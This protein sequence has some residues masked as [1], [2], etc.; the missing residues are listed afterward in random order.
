MQHSTWLELS[1]WN[2]AKILSCSSLPPEPVLAPHCCQENAHIA[3]FV[4]PVPSPSTSLLSLTYHTPAAGTTLKLPLLFWALFSSCPSA[5]AVPGSWD[6][7]P[8]LLSGHYFT[9]LQDP[10]YD[11]V[12]WLM[13]V[14]PA[15]WEAE[16][17][18]PP[19]VGSS[20]P[21]WPT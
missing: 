11:Q 5:H 17:G 2:G 9:Y 12:W 14:I 8:C 4:W 3:Q 18:G 1:K 16:A 21:A 7:F 6:T 15:L 10:V 13:P 20:R 19:G